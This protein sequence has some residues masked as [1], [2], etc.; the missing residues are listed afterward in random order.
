MNTDFMLLSRYLDSELNDQEKQ[1]VEDR[2]ESDPEL[3]ALFAL[4]REQND[5]F[6]NE[7]NE[8]DN[9]PLSAPLAAILAM[10]EQVKAPASANRF[11]KMVQTVR[12]Y[13]SWHRGV[14]WATACSIMFAL[15]LVMRFGGGEFTISDESLAQGNYT[16]EELGE[17]LSHKLTGSTET[18]KNVN[19][20]QKMA[21]IDNSGNLCKYFT[22]DRTE[23]VYHVVACHEGPQW[24][25]QFVLKDDT[26]IGHSDSHLFVP[27]KDELNS[28]VEK[29]LG[30]KIPSTPLTR[31]EE[32]MQ[33]EQLR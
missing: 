22:A 13:F 16:Q 5:R 23:N 11:S 29:Y 2:L 33:L 31:D 30:E 17:F 9:I 14:T 10:D 26:P 1:T 27:A 3:N 8:I 21:F 28:A 18:I 6:I 4:M 7:V 25:N 19:I 24:I 20:S 15:F 32:V 12:E